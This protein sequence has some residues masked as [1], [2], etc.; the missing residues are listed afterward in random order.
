[1][2]EQLTVSLEAENFED[3]EDVESQ[4]SVFLNKFSVK[5][6]EAVRNACMNAMKDQ[7]KEARQKKI[8][9]QL[10]NY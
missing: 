2:Q 3:V 6:K 10:I 1:M 5:L 4:A 7:L 9:L 8:L